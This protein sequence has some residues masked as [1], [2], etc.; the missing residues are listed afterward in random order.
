MKILFY[1]EPWIELQSPV[2]RRIWFESFSGTIEQWLVEF[3]KLALVR[4]CDIKFI[5]SDSYTQKLSL[6]TKYRSIDYI[7]ISQKE[8]SS[9]INEYKQ[10]HLNILK[11]K[12]ILD[13]TNKLIKSKLVGFVPDIVIT[14]TEND[15]LKKIFP[16]SLI[17]LLEM[18]I[19]SQSPYLA[20]IYFDTEVNIS[21]SYIKRYC[22][23][24]LKIQLAKKEKKLLAETRKHF[25]KIFNSNNNPFK[26]RLLHLKKKLSRLVILALQPSNIAM[27]FKH[28]SF[29]SQFDYMM[30]I[31][32]NLDKDIGI[33]VTEHR[34]EKILH[35]ELIEYLKNNYSNFIYLE[36]L[37]Y[38]ENTSQL[39][40]PFVDGVITTASTVGWQAVFYQK[41][42]F[43]LGNAHISAFSDANNI[44]DINKCLKNSKK[45]KNKDGALYHLFTR[46]WIN[47]VYVEDPKWVFSFLDKSL[48]RYKENK[49]DYDFYDLIDDPKVIFQRMIDHKYPNIFKRK[50]MP[51]INYN[52]MSNTKKGST[53]NKPLKRKDVFIFILFVFILYFVTKLF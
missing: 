13:A 24:L 16:N 31:L 12:K 46:Y 49:I 52:Q 15:F 3:K 27:T 53:M 18:G 26:E 5:C 38:Y 10:F 37:D 33:I 51:S 42:L 21:K 36:E 14:T 9:I 17:L 34:L 8:L 19:F 4:S 23:Q 40:L 32:N 47:F 1:I 2:W 29:E 41:Y 25:L 30:H 44:K 11:E 28:C 43:V 6:H 50:F 45:T 48:K 20:S 22:K 35:P 39:L 7:A